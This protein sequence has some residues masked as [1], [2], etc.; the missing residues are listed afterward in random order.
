MYSTCL[1]VVNFFPVISFSFCLCLTILLRW[2]VVGSWSNH[3]WWQQSKLECWKFV[4]YSYWWMGN[5]SFVCFRHAVLVFCIF[6]SHSH[7]IKWA[8]FAF[9]W[10]WAL[11]SKFHNFCFNSRIVSACL[12]NQIWLGIFWRWLQK[13]KVTFSGEGVVVVNVTLA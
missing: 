11:Y 3:Q 12:L 1:A 9:V 2:Y 13:S 8:F 6:H 4:C 7:P 10:T 5:S